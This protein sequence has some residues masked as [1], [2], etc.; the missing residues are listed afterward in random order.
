M[1]RT[2]AAGNYYVGEEGDYVMLVARGHSISCV[3]LRTGRL[4]GKETHV[5]NPRAITNKEFQELA[6][7]S[8]YTFISLKHDTVEALDAH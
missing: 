6:G 5:L 2:H 1:K 7:G 3:T 4:Y 8:F